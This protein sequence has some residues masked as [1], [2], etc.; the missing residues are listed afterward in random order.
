M[1]NKEIERLTG[2]SQG[3]IIGRPWNQFVHLE[4]KN[5]M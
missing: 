5:K 4:D 1:A 3:D 2:Y